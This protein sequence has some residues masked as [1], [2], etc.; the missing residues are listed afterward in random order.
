MSDPIRRV[1]VEIDAQGQVKAQSV[2]SPI[3]FGVRAGVGV[4]PS[5]IIPIVFVPGIMGSNLKTKASK[6]KPSE[7]AWRPPNGTMDAANQAF[8]IWKGRSPSDRQRLLDPDDTEVDDRGDLQVGWFAS[9][10]QYRE[11]GWGE[12]HWDSYGEWLQ[13]LEESLN[14][15]FVRKADGNRVIAAH[16]QSVIRADRGSWDARDLAALSEAELE[17]SAQYHYPVY[18]VGYNWLRCNSEAAARLARR[19]DTWIAEWKARPGYQCDKVIL[20][21]HSMGGLVC[22]AYAKRHPDKVLGIIHGVQPAVGA[23]LAYRRMACGTETGDAKGENLKTK[24]FATIAGKT[25]ADTIPVMGVSP[26]P[27]ELLPNHLHPPGWLKAL[28][29]DRKGTTEREMLSLPQSDPYDEIYRDMK[30]WYRLIDP[31]L[32]DPGKKYAT[33]FG[34]GETNGAMAKCIEAIGQAEHFHKEI[35]GNYYHPN[36]YA[37]YGRDADQLSYGTVRWAGTWHGQDAM[38]EAR[39]RQGKPASSNTPGRVIADFGLST[40]TADHP[41]LQPTN[42]T[43]PRPIANSSIE[44]HIQPQDAPGDGTVNWQSGEAPGLNIKRLF[45]TTGYDHQGSY[46]DPNMRQLTFHLICKIVQ[47]AA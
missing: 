47:G 40:A 33:D 44:F 7:I 43:R 3:R 14:R 1:P 23:P 12:I 30:S 18:A 36:T 38:H 2:T 27:L 25:P 22:R 41:A 11:R 35:I 26:G 24:G 34:Q 45:C 20:I 13:T 19:I 46:N 9:E 16:W 32:L 39:L 8:R 17:K 5:K 15:T 29:K 28:V 4:P 6:G 21:S 10:A 31:A 37:F 42:G